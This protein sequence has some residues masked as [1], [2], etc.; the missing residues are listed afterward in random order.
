MGWVAYLKGGARICEGM[1]TG[2][3]DAGVLSQSSDFLPAD[4]VTA[5]GYFP[6]KGN[7]LKILCEIDLDRGERFVRYWTGVWGLNAGKRKIYALGWY[8]DTDNGRKYN[9]LYFYTDEGKILISTN[10]FAGPPYTPRDTF[11][12]LPKDTL[13]QRTKTTLSWDNDGEKAYVISVPGGLLFRS[14]P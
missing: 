10:R 4:Q 11:A 12:L 6:I 5:I 2:M 3:N 14:K 7:Q 8:R 13:V 9:I 1:P